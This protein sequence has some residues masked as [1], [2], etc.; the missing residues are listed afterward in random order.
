MRKRVLFYLFAGCFAFQG[1]ALHAEEA[2]ITTSANHKSASDQVKVLREERYD[3]MPYLDRGYIRSEIRPE[4]I[5]Q[6]NQFISAKDKKNLD[7]LVARAIA[8]HTPARAAEERVALAKRRILAAV[9]GL[10][11]EASLKLENRTGELSD[12]EFNNKNYRVTLRQP[13]FRGGILWNTLL[14]EK[15]GLEAAQKEYKA[16]IEDLVNDVAAAYFEYNRAVQVLT[17]QEQIINEMKRYVNISQEK[18]KAEI[19]SEIENLNAQSLYSQ[20]Q[21]DHETSK[22]ELELAKLDLQKFLD[23]SLNDTVTTRSIYQVDQLLKVQKTSDDAKAAGDPNEVYEFESGRKVPAV[24][25]LMDLAYGHR[26]ELQVEAAKLESARYEERVR[27]GEMIPHADVVLEFG[28]LGEAFNTQDTNPGLRQE[29]RVLLDFNWNAAGNKINYTYES[30]QRAPSVTQFQSGT[31][32]ITRRNTVTFGVLDG[33]KEWADIKEAEVAKLDQVV[34]LEKTEKEVIYDVKQ[35]YFDYQKARIRVKSSLQRVDYR[36]R[37][38]ELA[39]FRLGKNEVQVSEYLQAE[40]D[41]LQELTTL[42]KALADY[43]TAKAKLNHSIGIRNYFSV[44]ELHGHTT[45]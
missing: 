22:Q 35:A 43:F 25:D 32:S 3:R 36:R 27:W 29:F 10:F 13:V 23:L 17:G 20:L 1:I 6:K 9:R 2:K 5:E 45:T 11:P 8:V 26:A 39:K 33:L 19:V 4:K 18:Y 12:Q 28:K 24:G 41:F 37:L 14:Q 42:H 15:A 21:Y 34:Q 16:V 7:E 44:E 38:A 30:D 40:I 31:G